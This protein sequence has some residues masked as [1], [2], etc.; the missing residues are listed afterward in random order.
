MD[1]A[2]ETELLGL[3]IARIGGRL[4]GKVARRLARNIGE[5]RVVV[6]GPVA[7]VRSRAERLAAEMGDAVESQPNQLA[8][9]T[10]T[11]IRNPAVVTLSFS[12]AAGGTA[13]DVRAVAAEG[14]IKQRTGEKTASTVGEWLTQGEA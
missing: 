8:W 5:C 7:E 11:G 3:G 9:I 12:P 13:V 6:P 14:L 1:E 10:R 2:T 4:S